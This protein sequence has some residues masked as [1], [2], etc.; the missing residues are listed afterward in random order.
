[1][2]RGDRHPPS[3][4]RVADS[5]RRLRATRTRPPEPEAAPEEPERPTSDARA[6]E[7]ADGDARAGAAPAPRAE[8]DPLRSV[9]AAKI[10][11]KSW[12][13]AT[14]EHRDDRLRERETKDHLKRAATSALPLFGAASG[15]A[16][17]ALA[18][19][20]EAAATSRDLA[21]AS[22]D[23][24]LAAAPESAPAAAAAAAAVGFGASSA[25]ALESANAEQA[26]L[27]VGASKL[28]KE[29]AA[30]E[31]ALAAM[32]AEQASERESALHPFPSRNAY[33]TPSPAPFSD[34]D[35]PDRARARAE[36]EALSAELDA[37]TRAADGVAEEIEKKEE[38][39]KKSKW[40]GLK[41]SK[42]L[43]ILATQ[44][45][46]IGAEHDSLSHGKKHYYGGAAREEFF[47]L[48]KKLARQQQNVLRGRIDAF[49][50]NAKLLGFKADDAAGADVATRVAMDAPRVVEDLVSASRA[51][52][53]AR[54]RE[55]A[56][57]RARAGRRGAVRVLAHAEA[58]AA[59][60]RATAATRAT[61]ERAARSPARRNAPRRRRRAD[62]P[63][64][65]RARALAD[66]AF[67]YL[68]AAGRTALEAEQRARRG[69][70]RGDAAH[71][72]AAPRER[73]LLGALQ[74]RTARATSFCAG[75]SRSRR[76]HGPQ[77][78]E[79]APAPGDNGDERDAAAGDGAGG[80]GAGGGAGAGAGSFVEDEGPLPDPVV[81]PVGMLPE[82]VILRATDSDSLDLGN[83]SLGDRYARPLRLPPLRSPDHAR[84]SPTS[85][86]LFAPSPSLRYILLL[87]EV[88]DELP[89]VR[90]L[91][92]RNNRL[93]DVGVNAI[94]SAAVRK[95]RPLRSFNI[96]MN[97][98]DEDAS[99]ALAHFLANR[100]CRLQH[101]YLGTADLDDFEIARLMKA[102]ESNA[103]L[104]TLDISDNI[105][106]GRQ[107][108]MLV[109]RVVKHDA[110]A[111]DGPPNPSA[112]VAVGG[113]AI[114]SMLEANSALVTLDLSWNRLGSKSGE[115]IGAALR[116]NIALTSLNLAYNAVGDDGAR[117]SAR[118][119]STTARSPRS[120]SRRTA[121]K[122]AARPCSPTGCTRTLGSGGSSSTATRSATRHAQPAA[123]AQLLGRGLRP[124]VPQ[125]HVRHGRPQERQ[126][127]PARPARG[128]S[129]KSASPTGRRASI[130]PTRSSARSRRRCCGS[131]R[132]ARAC[133]SSGC[134]AEHLR[135]HRAPG[136]DVQLVRPPPSARG[137]VRARRHWS[138]VAE[139]QGRRTRTRRRRRRSRCTRAST[140][141]RR[142]SGTTRSRSSRP[143]TASRGRCRARASSR[144]AWATSR[145]PRRSLSVRNATGFGELVRL[146]TEYPN[147][148]MRLLQ[149]G[150]D[151]AYF[152]ADQVQELLD[153]VA[154]RTGRSITSS[155]S[156]CSRTRCRASSTASTA[157]GSSTATSRATRCARCARGSADAWPVVVDAPTGRYSLDL[158]RVGNRIAPRPRSLS[159]LTSA[160]ARRFSRAFFAATRDASHL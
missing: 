113:R 157:S 107:E 82:P 158:S 26:A 122:T 43:H 118:R 123:R 98:I 50:E 86:L 137:R 31:G 14:R 21:P 103:L 141:A 154:R 138:K 120:R 99:I 27:L 75:C 7:Q 93:T 92:V 46:A 102:L 72:D 109:G 134:A 54:R 70:R 67:A 20:S 116:A 8:P 36:Q 69:R 23:A 13:T 59:S 42:K 155:C 49:D 76:R 147:E 112:E 15:R 149:L 83:R 55:S 80:G 129:S 79:D 45:R 77:E 32:H 117:R 52:R 28:D 53:E 40:K 84:E 108:H 10:A 143:R 16:V 57:V 145:A 105:I 1:M 11:A 121:S 104:R 35:G 41:S 62:A 66:A 17:A 151:D 100:R 22:N 2:P 156:T 88:I 114:A 91:S 160:R 125:L 74:S 110:E 64:R 152:C 5:Y 48:H 71:R 6:G 142:A 131:R 34:G 90:H 51:R 94:V 81:L 33:V 135:E 153:T 58:R 124:L 30:E 119:S 132:T 146:C 56:E 24:A 38:T 60:P 159:S 25:P 128:T 37:L 127:R 18:G 96:A 136:R 9:F 44:G 95:R 61:R 89:N 101:L 47:A 111:D 148:R 97:D 87:A 78:R 39:E 4:G 133:G 144:C 19:F 65:G 68:S 73:A 150:C 29:L 85:S 126:V 12:R 140:R 63:A 130:S 3:A 115:A 139:Q 106:G